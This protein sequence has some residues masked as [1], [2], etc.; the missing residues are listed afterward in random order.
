MLKGII[1][2]RD[3]A[4]NMTAELDFQE[5]RRIQ[6]ARGFIGLKLYDDAAEELSRIPDHLSTH[7]NVVR[8]WWELFAE[9]KDW[10]SC[11]KYA[12]QLS[13]DYPDDVSGYILLASSIRNVKGYTLNDA[14]AVL[15]SAADQFES[16]NCLTLY[17]D[18]A[19]CSSAL[20]NLDEARAWLDKTF[21]EAKGRGWEGFYRQMAIADPDLQPLGQ[22]P[23]ANPN[24]LS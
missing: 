21:A 12:L 22:Y 17:Y 6:F 7:P 16:S 23:P 1:F 13:I 11:A 10:E 24:G 19:C 4:T 2:C 20:G 9:K 18:L 14:Y 8:V 15:R 5:K 3:E